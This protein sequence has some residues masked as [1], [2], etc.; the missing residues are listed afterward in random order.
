ML[1]A[2]IA[3]AATTQGVVAAETQDK[4]QLQ[5]QKTRMRREKRL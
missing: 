1:T 3:L 5:Q 2:A 4:A